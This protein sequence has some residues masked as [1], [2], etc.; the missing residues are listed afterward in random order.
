ME[1]YSDDSDFE[2][3]KT[4]KMKNKMEKLPD[5]P[6]DNEESY[7]EPADD[8]FDY[9]ADKAITDEKEKEKKK[10]IADEKAKKAIAD[11]T[12][13][14]KNK[15]LDEAKKLNN[16]MKSKEKEMSMK[17]KTKDEMEHD[18]KI[19][20]EI[21][22]KIEESTGGSDSNSNSTNDTDGSSKGSG[23]K[24]K[25]YVHTELV[26]PFSTPLYPEIDEFNQL[27]NNNGMYI[28]G[29]SYV[30]VMVVLVS[31]MII[32]RNLNIAHRFN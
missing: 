27:E 8:M 28:Q 11:M 18:K 23:K 13:A 1:E 22:K 31:L 20:D 21:I 14:A 3:I 12:A 32:F 25:T 6:I 4:K 29:F 17:T 5:E 15:I 30:V 9:H 7:Y 26:S 19:E 2:E 10:K 16:T 24:N